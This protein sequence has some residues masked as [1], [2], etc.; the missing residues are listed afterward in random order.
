[1]YF[2]FLFFFFPWSWEFFFFVFFLANCITLIHNTKHNH[3]PPGLSPPLFVPCLAPSQFT[4]DRTHPISVL[5]PVQLSRLT[6]FTNL[7]EQV[8]SQL[9]D[10]V[11]ENDI[12]PVIYPI[13]KWKN[14][15]NK[16]LYESAHSAALAVFSAQK[17]VS[18]EL[19]GIYAPLLVEVKSLL[20]ISSSPN[21]PFKNIDVFIYLGCVDPSIPKIIY[22]LLIWVNFLIYFF[23]N[24]DPFFY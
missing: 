19:T 11:L 5:S 6:Y 3:N 10:K 17:E 20:S 9:E 2:T 16:E 24:G 18:R 15:E 4:T 21:L 8:M 7:I 13:L 23:Y 12:L 22:Y 14:P 1:M